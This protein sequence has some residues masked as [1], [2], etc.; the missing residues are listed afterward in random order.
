MN[1]LQA[2]LK[3][4]G[5]IFEPSSQTFN[6]KNP[7]QPIQFASQSGQQAPQQ[8]QQSPVASPAIQN[9][10]QMGQGE[11]KYQMGKHDYSSIKPQIQ[12]VLKGTPLEQYADN[13]IEA[14]NKHG[15]DPRV[16]ITVANNES[17]LGKTYPQD[18]YNPFGYNASGAGHIQGPDGKSYVNVDAGLKQA[19]F[20][21]LPMAIDRLTQRF[22]DHPFNPTGQG[23]TNFRQDPTVSN[24]QM[25]YNSAPDERA[26]YLKNAQALVQQFR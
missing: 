7:G 6:Y 17:S 25:A 13:F 2:A 1:P 15:V 23:Y 24:L 9:A 20:T 18:S 21:S 16:L 5:G 12:A 8:P 10:Q 19:G 11:F 26:N 14:G 4:I 22:S 3:Y